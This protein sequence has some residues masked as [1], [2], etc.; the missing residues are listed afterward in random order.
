MN[1]KNKYKEEI[2]R[3][4]QLWECGDITREN[5]EYIFPE[6]AESEDERIRKAI[7]TGLIDCRDAPDLGWSDFGGIVIDDCIDW[8]KKQGEQKDINPTLLEKEKMDN[9]FTKMMFKDKTVLEAIHEEKVDN[10]NKIE[11]KFHEGDWIVYKNDICQ[12]V[13]CEEGCNKLVT[14]FGIEK[15][16]V[17]E[18]NLSTA[19]LWNIQDAKDGDVLLTKHNQP[20]IYNGIF[21]EECVGAYCGICCLGDEFLEAILPCNWSCK[22]GVKPTTKEQCDLLFQKMKEAGYKWDAEKKEL[23]R[24]E[25]QGEQNQ[26]VIMWHDVSDKPNEMKEILVEWE[27]DDATWHTVGFYNSR[28]D[29]FRGEYK[30]PIDNVVR[31]MYVDELSEKERKNNNDK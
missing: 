4:T 20:F 15:E 23:I 3:A 8:L 7:L 16:L 10:V 12:I 28:T 30:I 24:L 26:S 17:N 19:R 14:T 22:E 5:L 13:K 1:D 2:I 21:D 9:A 31:W 27:S 25:K 11:Q 18:R 29:M 6:L